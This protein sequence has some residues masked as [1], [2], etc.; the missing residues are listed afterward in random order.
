MFG[1]CLEVHAGRGRIQWR[2]VPAEYVL[3]FAMATLG[4]R[5]VDPLLDINLQGLAE[6]GRWLIP[7][8]VVTAEPAGLQCEHFAKT[9][10][11]RT[12][13]P[14]MV[15]WEPA[16]GA[17]DPAPPPVIEDVIHWL[18][19]ATGRLPVVR[20][21]RVPETALMRDCPRM[22]SPSPEHPKG[23]WWFWQQ[24]RLEVVPGITGGRVD[25]VWWNGTQDELEPFY[26]SG[27][28]PRDRARAAADPGGGAGV[29][30]PV[31]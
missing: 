7:F 16:F 8:H 25:H 14:T 9:V 30:D 20:A 24:P 15:A 12:G 4:S 23:P 18:E 3:V 1:G 6:T 21:A 2:D 26:R 29:A 19:T 27:Q 17:A 10:G 31:S 11:L 28:L 13:G 5:Y 22:V